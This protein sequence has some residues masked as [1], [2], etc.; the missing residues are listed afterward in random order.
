MRLIIHER[1]CVDTGFNIPASSREKFHAYLAYG[2]QCTVQQVKSSQRQD[3]FRLLMTDQ[4]ARRPG[5][6]VEAHISCTFTT[7][8]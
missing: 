8:S 3:G 2:T 1:A 4:H 7:L 6:F 5:C